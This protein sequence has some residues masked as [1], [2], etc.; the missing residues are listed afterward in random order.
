MVNLNTELFDGTE[1][2]E[3][4]LLGSLALLATAELRFQN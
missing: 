2:R 3:F 4:K 1:M